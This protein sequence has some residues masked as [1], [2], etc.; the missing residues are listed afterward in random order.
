MM[1]TITL[2]YDTGNSTVRQ[3]L[4]GLISSGLFQVQSE[5]EKERKAIQENMHIAHEMIADIR[6]N[7]STSY[8]NIDGFLDSLK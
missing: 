8:Q 3:L 6:T 7:G 5:S 1:G 2:H 4:D